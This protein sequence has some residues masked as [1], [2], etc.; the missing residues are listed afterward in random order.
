M[1]RKKLKLNIDFHFSMF[2]KMK[3]EH[4]FSI[5]IFQFL[6]KGKLNTDFIFHF[7]T[8]MN[9]PNRGSQWGCSKHGTRLIFWMFY[10]TRLTPLRPSTNNTVI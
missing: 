10:A 8:E 9:D 2:R 6:K 3:I 5:F 7:S 4:Q 1:F